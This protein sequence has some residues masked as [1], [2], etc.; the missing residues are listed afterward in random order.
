MKRTQI[1][2]LLFALVLSLSLLAGCSS[3]D[4][5]TQSSEQSS[6]T[7]AVESSVSSDENQSAAEQLLTDITGT[8]QELWPVL[9][10]D[11]YKQ[12]WLDASAKFV[13]EDDAEA[14]VQKL[15]SMVTATI[16]GEEA[17][18]A[19]Q[20]GD[21]RYDCSFTQG[22]AQFQ[23][24][25]TTIKG[26]DQSGSE[27][28]SHTYHFVGMEDIN[29]MYEYESDD[30]DSGEFTYFCLAPD[31]SATTYHIEFRYGSDLEALAQYDAGSYAYWMASGISVDCD[32]DMIENC[33][34][35]FCTENLSE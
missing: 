10:A 17:V 13:G 11:E 22:V 20:D 30:T 24:D 3:T 9:L 14:T 2:C 15:Q 8:Y 35:L 1:S 6:E 19:Y 27:L 31:T 4:T 33:I 29:G 34:E 21:A 23:F 5:T 16:Y 18:S 28:F 7:S 12:I 26:F 32:Q 25:G